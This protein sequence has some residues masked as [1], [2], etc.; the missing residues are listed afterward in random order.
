M[1]NGEHFRW[2]P[3]R[4]LPLARPEYEAGGYVSA[5]DLSAEQRYRLERLMHHDR[6]SHGEGV[7]CGLQVVEGRVAAQPWAVRVCPGYAIGC[8]GEE[9][10]IRAP[11]L[12]DIRDYVWNAPSTL[13][14]G[15]ARPYIG[16]RYIECAHAAVAAPAPGC[17]CEDTHYEPSRVADGYELDVL[18]TV[19]ER[20]G[21]RFDLCVPGTPPCTDCRGRA[22]VLLAR[23]TLPAR[24]SEPISASQ[25]ENV[26]R[27]RLFA[28]TTVQTQLVECCCDPIDAQVRPGT[29][30]QRLR[31]R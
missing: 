19:D 20:P 15:P 27:K 9:I 26:A 17:R 10:E 6:Y 12:V 24:D 21:M 7:V 11:V 8:C 2:R 4:D 25:I 1:P 30:A 18:W 13:T 28:T 31:C 23:V 5:G 3:K 29:N 14:R 22:Y 16:V